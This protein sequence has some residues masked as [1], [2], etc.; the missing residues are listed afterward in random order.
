MQ[1]RPAMSIA[2]YRFGPLTL[3][4]AKRELQRDGAVIALPARAFECLGYLI[5]HR[6]RAVDRDELVRAVFGR[7]DVSDAQLAQIVL[8]T[9]R[10]IGDDGHEQRAIRTVPR[11]GFRWVAPVSVEYSD[12]SVPMHDVIAS[13]H[14]APIAGGAVDGSVVDAALD[15]EAIGSPATGSHRVTRP[16]GLVLADWSFIAAAVLVVATCFGPIPGAGSG[17]AN[18]SAQVETGSAILVLPMQVA[19]PTDAAWARLGMMDFVVGRMRLAGLPVLSSEATLSI[20]RGHGDAKA[21][22]VRKSA[23]ASWVVAARADRPHDRWQV[24]LTATDA[25]GLVQRGQASHT[26]LVAA[27][28]IASDRLLATLGGAVPATSGELPGLD[29]RLQRAQSAMLANELDTARRILVEAP[30]LQR[31]Q[32]QLRYRLAQLDF[33]AGRYQQGVASIDEL[34]PGDAARRDPVFHARLFNLRGA[35]LIRLDRYREAERSYDQA[36]ALLESATGSPVELGHALLGRGVTRSSQ[37]NF[38]G[39]LSDFGMA[40]VKLVRAGDRLSVARVDANLGNL[41]MDRGRPVQAVPYYEKA[42]VDFESMG[43]VN[44]LTG[45]RG[46]LTTAHL[47][48]LQPQQALA[49]NDKAW[50][51]RGRVRDPSQLADLKLCRAE[52]LTAVGRLREAR[53]LL[54]ETENATFAAGD[55][56][57]REYLQMDLARQAGDLRSTVLLAQDALQGWPAGILPQLRAWVVLRQHEAALAADLPAPGHDSALA[58]D[59]LTDQ[60]GQALRHRR[61]GQDAAAEASYR[62]ALAL[63]DAR[64]IPSEIASAVV[65][66]A[67]WLM[68]DGQPGEA[69]ALIGRVTPWAD[70]DFALAL[71]QVELYRRL[72]Q[73]MQWRAALEHA[74]RLAGE[75]PIPAELTLARAPENPA[76]A[77]SS[78]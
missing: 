22:D 44:E 35:L 28:R 12:A 62:K 15:R 58:G 13:D 39:A 24:Q 21:A 41:E 66:H 29:E 77:P 75:R 54:R 57:R 69:A 52:V 70:R 38:D 2:R 64:G 14:D 65:A 10:A 18:S 60:L 46:M 26:D 8:R 72:G 31:S 53:D 50:A 59:A 27:T 55:Y 3:E 48:L 36:I 11:F 67:R 51:M 74:Q 32:P 63:A 61:A 34:L 7:A 40:R 23:G 16:R 45:I 56:R 76:A 49:V 78:N 37:A 17:Q 47:Q 6:D 4:L 5:E 73:P 43:A 68:Q 71:L 30:E 9:R 1:T 20:L 33:R 19:G 42:T 25:S